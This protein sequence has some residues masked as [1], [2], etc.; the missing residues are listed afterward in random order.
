[1]E[2]LVREELERWDSDV[3]VRDQGGRP[4]SASSRG[5]AASSKKRGQ[6]SAGNRKSPGGSDTSVRINTVSRTVFFSIFIYIMCDKKIW[7]L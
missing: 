3:S 6:K 1:M 2:K 5:S 7:F 4:A